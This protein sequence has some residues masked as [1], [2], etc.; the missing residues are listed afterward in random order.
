MSFQTTVDSINEMKAE[1]ERATGV[2]TV[3]NPDGTTSSV[4][5]EFSCERL[6]L[7]LDEHVSAVTDVLDAKT[8]EIAAI[9]SK[10]API[11]SIPSD[12]LKIIGWAKKVVTGMVDPQLSAAIQLATEMAQLAGALASLASAVANAATR[13]ADC[14]ESEIRGALDDI[15]D[16]LM[17]NATSLFDQATSIYEDIRDDALDQL[18]YNELLSLSTDVQAQ[19]GELDTALADIGDATTNIQDSIDDLTAIQIPA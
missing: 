8:A 6:E 17:A 18:G 12:P 14:I 3:E 9:M 13:L 4:P 15:T 16:S 7:L 11:M 19:I 5:G 10:Y 2:T 1:L